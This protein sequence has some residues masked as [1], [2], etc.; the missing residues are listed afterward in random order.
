MNIYIA[1]LIMSL[2]TYSIRITP[3]ILIKKRIKSRFFKSF[4]FYAPYVT[5]SVLTFP[6]ILSST[7]SLPSS[8][9]GFATAL[10]CALFNLGLPLT[11]LFST[12]VAFLTG[13]FF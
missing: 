7:P 11:A 2:I 9:F 12:L 6:S 10:L 3:L 1:I 8:L 5:L 13:L 4:L